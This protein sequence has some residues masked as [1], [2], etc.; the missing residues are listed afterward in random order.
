MNWKSIIALVAMTG[1]VSAATIEGVYSTH[2]EGCDWR[3]VTPD[4]YP[5]NAEEIA[6]LDATGV[7]GWEWGCEFLSGHTN[8]YEQTVYIASCGAEGDSWPNLMLVEKSFTGDG[9]S[10]ITKD[11]TN[12]TLEF[13]FKCE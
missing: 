12:S 7:S 8:K 11:E 13:P 9:Y 6:Y 4:N 3:M 2:K 5:D 1:Q 10:V